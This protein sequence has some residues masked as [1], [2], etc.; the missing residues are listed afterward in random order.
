MAMVATM[1]PHQQQ[2]HMEVWRR[3]GTLRRAAL[4]PLS[5]QYLHTMLWHIAALTL[6]ALAPHSELPAALKVWL[7]A[8]GRSSV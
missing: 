2:S 5:A 7:P 1:Q 3:A 4:F 8:S 6:K